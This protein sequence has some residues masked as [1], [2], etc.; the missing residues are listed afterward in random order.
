MASWATCWLIYARYDRDTPKS[1]PEART[2]D[3][4]RGGDCAVPAADCWNYRGGR[5]G[6]R[7]LSVGL[8]DFFG[9]VYCRER[10]ADCEVSMGVGA[11]AGRGVSADGLQLLGVFAAASS[12]RGCARASEP[13]VLSIFDSA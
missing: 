7:A 2:A 8:F 6:R 11:G 3:A 4:G 1:R 9:G 12:S 13:G 10:R 5:G